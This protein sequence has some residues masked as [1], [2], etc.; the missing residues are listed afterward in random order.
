MLLRDTQLRNCSNIV[1]IMRLPWRHN[2]RGS[3]SAMQRHWTNTLGLWE[4]MR[5]SWSVAMAPVWVACQCWSALLLITLKNTLK[6]DWG[7]T[8]HYAPS[9]LDLWFFSLTLFHAI[10]KNPKQ[11]NKQTKTALARTSLLDLFFVFFSAQFIIKPHMVD[12]GQLLM[13]D[14]QMWHFERSKLE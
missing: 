10:K 5:S 1:Y 9:G 13:E 12:Y 14:M 2:K 6:T 3:D 4:L 8:T 11:T 7:N